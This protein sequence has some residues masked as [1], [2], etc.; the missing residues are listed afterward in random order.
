MIEA[1]DISTSRLTASACTQLR[2]LG[3]EQVCV[4]L[5]YISEANLHVEPYSIENLHI[6]AS[7][8]EYGCHAYAYYHLGGNVRNRALWSVEVVA[9]EPRCFAMWNDWEDNGHAAPGI[10]DP[11]EFPPERVRDLILEVK[12]TIG[13][14]VWQMEYTAG[15]W[16]P[17]ATGKWDG[18]KDCELVDANYARAIGFPLATPYGG[19][20]GCRIHQYAGTTDLAGLSVDRNLVRLA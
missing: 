19:W 3:V 7:E 10:P 15:W 8:F 5:R 4:G 16:W 20:S 18:L 1:I 14:S 13:G 2:D 17:R 12:D 11:N 9:L 6:A